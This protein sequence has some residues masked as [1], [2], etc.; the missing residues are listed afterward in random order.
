MVNLP[1]RRACM[2]L[3]T[4]FTF[5]SPNECVV[6]PPFIELEGLSNVVRFSAGDAPDR[7]HTTIEHDVKSA[8]ERALDRSITF[9]P[10]G[11]NDLLS[12]EREQWTDGANF[13]SPAPGVVIGYERNPQTF[14]RMRRN[15]YHVVSAQ[16][17]LNYHAESGFEPGEKIAI[18]L[19]GH[20]LSR[21][22]GGPRC[23]TMP[24]T[25]QPSPGAV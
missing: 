19:A 9:I 3:D 24:L 6:Y 17:F 15:G 13:F 16:G 8:L 10:C 14:A 5:S 23:M 2:H 22:R 7:L 25:R 11:G 1:K 20:E 18:K 21:G 12:Q 4:I